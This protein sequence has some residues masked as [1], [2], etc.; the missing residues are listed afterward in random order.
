MGDPDFRIAPE[1]DEEEGSVN[2]ACSCNKSE[3]FLVFV[4]V[5]NS[6]AGFCVE[7]R[8]ASW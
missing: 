5:R 4:N 7:P 3:L 6:S 2:Q 1:L 8:F